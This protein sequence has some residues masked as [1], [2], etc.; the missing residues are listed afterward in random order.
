MSKLM[1]AHGILVLNGSHDPEVIK[2]SYWDQSMSVVVGHQQFHLK[3]ELLY[4]SRSS[5]TTH[6]RANFKQTS[7]EGS[8][9]DPLQN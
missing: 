8:L 4:H 3:D 7:Q 5:Y 9:C 1:L 6:T 2:V